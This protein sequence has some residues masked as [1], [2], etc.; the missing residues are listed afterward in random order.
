MTPQY[1]LYGALGS[2]SAIVELMLAKAGVGYETVEAA[3]WGDAAQRALL[4]QVNPLGQVPTLVTPSGTILTESA[5][6]AFHIHDHFPASAL[7]P[8]P[9]TP[10]RDWCMRWLIFLVAAIY[11]SFTYGDEPSRWVDAGAAAELRS[12]TDRWRQN[13]WRMV[14]AEAA[15]PW[16]LGDTPSVIDLY[17]A[18]MVEWRPRR[19]WFRD[20]CPKLAAIAER[21]ASDPTFAAI[22]DRHRAAAASP[23]P[24]S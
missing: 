23:L 2:G 24:G 14:E 3:P 18:V 10:A 20:N 5:A 17:I 9:A 12:R 11:P 16:F 13:L 21:V 22:L 15:I 4:G 6:I 8:P 7:L 1:R 19:A